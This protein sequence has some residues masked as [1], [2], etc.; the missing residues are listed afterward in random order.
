MNKQNSS[1]NKIVTFIKGGK[2]TIFLPL[3]L[4]LIAIIY[5][6]QSQTTI[7]QNTFKSKVSPAPILETTKIDL[8]VPLTQPNIRQVYLFYSFY[9]RIKTVKTIE[10][11]VQL[12]LD[13]EDL[14]LPEFIVKP[15]EAQIIKVDSVGPIA[16]PGNQKNASADILEPGLTVNIQIRYDLRLYTWQVIRVYVF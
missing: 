14:S 6:F 16:G 13:V 2:L 15:H 7:F 9:G 1:F 3:F 5:V 8:P 11:G 4:V 12:I 10:G